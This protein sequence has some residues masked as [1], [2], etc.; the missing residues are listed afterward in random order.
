MTYNVFGGMLNLNQSINQKS[1]WFIPAF[2]S[3]SAT[4][5]NNGRR[6]DLTVEESGRRS[7]F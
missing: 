1:I 7:Y 6:S 3:I 4:C 2:P 5:T